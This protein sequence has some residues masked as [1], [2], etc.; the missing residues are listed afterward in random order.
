MSHA[1]PFDSF[2]DKKFPRNFDCPGLESELAMDV[3]TL[4][5]QG[6]GDEGTPTLEQKE[7]PSSTTNILMSNRTSFPGGHFEPIEG[8]S[9]RM[10]VSA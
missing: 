9:V 6:M 2:F 3:S 10:W 1:L 7:P 4:D 8:S 5:L